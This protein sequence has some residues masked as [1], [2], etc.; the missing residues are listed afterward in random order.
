MRLWL[1]QGEIEKIVHLLLVD[2]YDPRYQHAMRS[3]KYV[4]K[5]F[6]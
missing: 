1:R 3:Y 6:C 4:M 2:Y 5:T